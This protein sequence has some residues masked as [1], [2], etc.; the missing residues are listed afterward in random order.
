MLTAILGLLPL[1]KMVPDL[2]KSIGGLIGGKTEEKIN[3]GADFVGTITTAIS[4]KEISPAQ[5][6]AIFSTILTNRK[7]LEAQNLELAKFYIDAGMKQIE[8]VNLTMRAET[9]AEHWPTYSWRP[10][11]GFVS[12]TAFGVVSYFIC[13]LMYKIVISIPDAATALGHLPG[14]I[15]AIT[16]LFTIPGAILGVAAWQR[17]KKQREEIAL[18][19]SN[20]ITDLAKIEEIVK[21]KFAELTK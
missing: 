5:Q 20:S 13:K 11:W 14:I 9:V 18:N 4:K 17:G 21:K 6:Q 1:I 7:E 8:S 12:G 15:T 10:Y 19:T 16:A 2:A 3:Q